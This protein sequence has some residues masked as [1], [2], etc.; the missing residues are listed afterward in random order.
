MAH[1]DLCCPPFTQIHRKETRCRYGLP[2]NANAGEATSA[3]H[4]CSNYW[5]SNELIMKK[6]LALAAGVLIALPMSASAAS[7]TNIQFDNGQTTTTCTAGQSVHAKIRISVPAGEVAEVGQADVLGDNLAPALPF[8]LNPGNS[9][10]IQSGFPKD[11]DTTFP[12]P[13]NTGYYT[14]ELR[15]AGI[16]G[17]DRA[18]SMTDG[19]VTVQTFPNALHVVADGILTQGPNT[20][21]VGTTSFQDLMNMIADLNAQIS[22]M[23]TGGVYA[24]KV[25]TPKP[26]PTTSSACVKLNGYNSF[27]YG[28]K[29]ASV[30]LAQKF[31][32][33]NGGSIPAGATGF[34]GTQSENALEEA[35]DAN[36]CN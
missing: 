20:G 12:C 27:S 11:V 35:L 29:G 19:V 18:S 25:C 1:F 8:D 31:I 21:G 17:G 22:C 5:K 15:T 30:K 2:S 32:M 3:S 6:Y 16:F 28:D 9:L 14:P 24:N 23:V 4:Q 13:Q 34:W 10:G 26:A 33:N 7:I 36:N